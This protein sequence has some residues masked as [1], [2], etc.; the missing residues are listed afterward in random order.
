MD[1]LSYFSLAIVFNCRLSH[2]AQIRRNTHA[3]GC[4]RYGYG[5]WGPGEGSS[6]ENLG[7]VFGPKSS[8]NTTERFGERR[9]SVGKIYVE[10]SMLLKCKNERAEASQ[11]RTFRR[12][13][14]PCYTLLW[15]FLG[16]SLRT[17]LC[18]RSFLSALPG[19]VFVL[20]KAFAAKCSCFDNGRTVPP[21]WEPSF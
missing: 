8:A 18:L 1:S 11:S 16:F 3:L 17:S 10:I 7:R 20:G 14:L 9:M 13:L 2:N 5:F 19:F 4:C 21:L 15:H 12:E 6:G